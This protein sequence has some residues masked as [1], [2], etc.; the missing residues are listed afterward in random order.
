MGSPHKSGR[1]KRPHLKTSSHLT[2]K[3]TTMDSSAHTSSHPNSSGGGESYRWVTLPSIGTAVK[4]CHLV[5]MK[6]PLSMKEDDISIEEGGLT[7]RKVKEALPT[8]VKVV[9]LVNIDRKELFRNGP[10]MYTRE[11]VAE[12]G[13]LWGQVH[14]SP[15]GHADSQPYPSEEIVHQFFKEVEV[16]NGLVAVH[17]AHGLNRTGYLI[18]RYLIQKCGV[19]PKEAVAR[20]NDARGYP[21]RRQTLLDHLF[22]RDWETREEADCKDVVR[23]KEVGD[24]RTI[25]E[26]RGSSLTEKRG[27]LKIFKEE[28][29]ENI[30]EIRQE[31]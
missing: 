31:E 10:K 3:K 15:L 12:E 17:C 9:S 29:G 1:G 20:F 16:D 5:P 6:V 23:S 28:L 27:Q 24:R 26:G 22:S 21:M 7:I 8:V 14:C 30:A 25:G 2:K 4:G 11:E 13:L 19:E 18:C